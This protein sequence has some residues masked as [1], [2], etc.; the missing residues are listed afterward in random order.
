MVETVRNL[1]AWPIKVLWK[2]LLL[3]WRHIYHYY[4]LHTPPTDSRALS[5]TNF[6][7]IY[8]LK[9][10]YF[11]NILVMSLFWP[12]R[13]LD[14]SVALN[15][16]KLKPSCCQSK[17]CKQEVSLLFLFYFICHSFN[18]WVRTSANRQIQ[19]SL[20]TLLKNSWTC[21]FFFHFVCIPEIR[22][23][24]HCYSNDSENSLR[25]SAAFRNFF[26]CV[27]N[28]FFLNYVS[29]KQLIMHSCLPNFCLHFIMH[30]LVW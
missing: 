1:T 13:R 20:C 6:I 4:I 7:Y 12:L 22:L 26:L 28:N 2:W 10:F 11:G 5:E 8:I 25:F 24:Y 27:S 29:I 23:Y 30:F 15:I 9:R 17:C 14:S 19:M 3:L 21:K 18:R 16:P